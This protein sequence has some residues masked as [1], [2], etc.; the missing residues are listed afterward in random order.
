M[1]DNTEWYRSG[2]V[3]L[4]DVAEQAEVSWALASIVLRHAP[5]ASAA[6]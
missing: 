3:T 2:R 1:T 6:A 4:S 5:G